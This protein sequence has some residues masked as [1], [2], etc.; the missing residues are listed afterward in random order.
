MPPQPENHFVNNYPIYENDPRR[1]VTRTSIF[2]T[3]NMGKNIDD[4]RS[5]TAL[6]QLALT[7]EYAASLNNNALSNSLNVNPALN[8]SSNLYSGL[9]PKGIS[10]QINNLPSTNLLE[11]RLTDNLTSG[12]NNIGTGLTDNLTSTA[13]N[14]TSG[15]NN[16]G[17]GIADNINNATSK[18][19]ELTSGPSMLDSIRSGLGTAVDNV[20]T[21]LGNAAD[22]VNNAVSGIGSSAKE[23]VNAIKGLV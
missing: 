8:N 4:F 22:S 1:A 20:G 18:V 11:T 13:N 14:L 2:D 21:G 15:V 5:R 7:P 16:I 10:S 19:N 17:S 9:V 3:S 12:L 23:G 6:P